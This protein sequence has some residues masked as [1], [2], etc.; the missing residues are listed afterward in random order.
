MRGLDRKSL[1]SGALGLKADARQEQGQ[2]D[3]IGVGVGL[4]AVQGY[5][6][7]PAD[8]TLEGVDLPLPGAK[9]QVALPVPVVEELTPGP[10]YPVGDPDALP[11][12]QL[13]EVWDAGEGFKAPFDALLQDY[14][15]A[16][17]EQLTTQEGFD[18][19]M[20]LA[21]SRRDRVKAM[22]ITESPMLFSQ[23]NV[24]SRERTMVADGT[25]EEA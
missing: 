11:T 20:R 7:H 5:G 6:E 24:P 17:A 22:P 15:T 8:R 2:R 19:Y 1:E 3:Q 23:T 10:E 12:P 21:E 25:V 4:V 9:A 14:Y 13:E 18:S 16:F